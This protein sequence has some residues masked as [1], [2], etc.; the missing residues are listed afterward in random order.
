MSKAFTKEDDGVPA[1]PARKRG[2]P[3]PEPNYMTA[4]GVQAARA[5]LEQLA[6][7]A[8]DPD[9]IR[10]LSDHLATAQVVAPDDRGVVGL[11]AAVT[12][13]DESGHRTT[14]RLVGAIEADPKR[15]RLSWQTPIANALWGAR[16]GDAIELP[17]GGEVEVV[18][19]E[20]D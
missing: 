1:P 7:D 4:A 20:Y 11:G 18:A 6:R 10:E 15:G 2:V 3:V 13:E 17:R 14:Y 5:E 9:R 16:V 19:I 12:V 8:G